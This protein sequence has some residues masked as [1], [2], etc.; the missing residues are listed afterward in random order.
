MLFDMWLV[1]NRMY[2]V[3]A[4]SPQSLAACSQSCAR[5]SGSDSK[6]DAWLQSMPAE[7]DSRQIL[8]RVFNCK[9]RKRREHEETRESD[10]KKEKV[11]KKTEESDNGS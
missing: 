10:K 9:R 1:T 6:S 5:N 4:G 7:Q 3:L 2:A 11:D 8:L